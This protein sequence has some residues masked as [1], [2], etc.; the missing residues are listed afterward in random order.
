MNRIKNNEKCRHLGIFEFQEWIMEKVLILYE[1]MFL[2]R[3]RVWWCR[4]GLLIPLCAPLDLK[5]FHLACLGDGRFSEEATCPT[6]IK[7]QT[8]WTPATNIHRTLQRIKNIFSHKIR[9]FSII[10]SW[11]S[12]LPKCRLLPSFLIPFIHF[13]LGQFYFYPG[14]F[15]S[16]CTF[17]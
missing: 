1:K 6:T 14:L 8:K 11:N 7:W 10:H 16:I 13:G 5:N 2:I 9:T 12:N 15:D 4:L 17:F 3:C